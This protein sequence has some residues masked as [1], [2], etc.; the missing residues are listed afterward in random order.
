MQTS[1]ENQPGSLGADHARQPMPDKKT[2]QVNVRTSQKTGKI[3]AKTEGD[4]FVEERYEYNYDAEG[5]LTG[6]RLNGQ[7]HE[8][9]S[10]SK[11]GQR[12]TRST[13][14]TNETEYFHYDAQGRLKSVNQMTWFEYDARG[15]TVARKGLWYLPDGVLR[16]GDT[17]YHYGSGTLL[18]AVQLP[19]DI[20]LRYEYSRESANPQGPVRRFRNGE[21]T[22][23]YTWGRSEAGFPVLAACR[24]YS[25]GLE[26]HF[27]YGKRHCPEQVTILKIEAGDTAKK[28]SL[29]TEVENALFAAGQ[30]GAV[31]DCGCDQV[32]S[33]KRLQLNGRAIKYIDY[34]SFGEVLEETLPALRLPLGFASG[35]ADPDSMLVRFGY[36]DYDP[37]LGRFLCLDPARDRRGDGD[38]YDYCMDDPVNLID[39]SGLWFQGGIGKY[40][41][42]KLGGKTGK[43][44]ASSF[45]NEKLNAPEEMSDVRLRIIAV[46][47]KIKNGTATLDD[48]KHH[49]RD[50]IRED[51]LWDEY[52][53]H[54]IN[55]HNYYRQRF[56]SDDYAKRKNEE[57]KRRR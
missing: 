46:E 18:D 24:D 34:D 36:R 4:G 53:E 41:I 20:T 14:R 57:S 39:P 7:A 33:L 55:E 45:F 31:L 38:L 2:F 52:G 23:E 48:Y 6:V 15:N 12:E 35:L 5:R 32:G 28:G 40:I 26:F 11:A 9:Y 27:R 49:A 17:L 25:Q 56:P 21:L 22:H 47:D 50:V 10:Y 30:D 37:S 19:G 16:A 29:L 8:R 3:V 43:K 51:E 1:L 54:Y 42:K 44:I 13:P